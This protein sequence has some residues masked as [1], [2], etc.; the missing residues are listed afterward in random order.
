[1]QTSEFSPKLLESFSGYTIKNFFTDSISGLTVAIVAL[2]LAMAIAIASNL[3]PEKGLFTAIVAGFLI[4]ALG[5]SR[6]QIG[7]PTAAFAVTV[8]MVAAKHGYSGL[9]L[10]TIMAG[11]MLIIFGLLR[12]G[13]LIKFIPY[14][15]VTGF[16]SG[17]AILIFFSQI[18]DFFG[19]QT[20]FIPPDFL[21]KAYVYF[22]HINTINPYAATIGLMS[23]GVIL[24]CQKNIPKVPGPLVVVIFGSI[25]TYFFDLPI[26]TIENTFGEIP[27]SLPMPE[28]PTFTLEEARAV[29]P[30]AI[31][32]A[33]LAGIESLLSAIVADGMTGDRHKSNVELLAQG[34][35]NIASVCFGGIPA[36]GAIARTATNVK[37]GAISPI[38]GMMHA[39]WLALFMFVF[40]PIIAKAPLAVLSAILMVI[41]WN[42]SEIKHFRQILKAPKSD[43]A[44]LIT[45][46]ILTVLVDLNFA[47]QAGISLASL[48]FIHKMTQAGEIKKFELLDN[49]F[50]PDATAKKVLPSDTQV[51]EIIGPLFF[52]IADKLQDTLRLMKKPPK[53]F[54]LRMRH[55][56]IIDASGIHALEQL[57]DSCKD[58]NTILILSGVNNIVRDSLNKT[59]ISSKIGDENIADHI[60]GAILR[61]YEVLG[62]N[63]PFCQIFQTKDK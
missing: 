54:I 1:M 9:V 51:Y 46:L 19:L 33:V 61:A 8:A 37:S 34:T 25:L 48:L 7:G 53:V 15:V 44:V 17:I 21:H 22:E 18:K 16:T 28:I 57:L 42:M 23:I 50:D 58:Q 27:R 38:S 20:P 26:A 56:P 62:L 63:A 55:V 45:T 29:L 4:S 32:I 35:A 11:I 39:V 3:S 60:D 10:A 49:D 2:P 5:G 14:P 31:T 40:A 6:F 30:D 13:A 52:G 36:T 47:V 12:G 41:A 59:A 43:R 24:F